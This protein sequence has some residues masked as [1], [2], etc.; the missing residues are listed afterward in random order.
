MTTTLAALLST[1]L[2]IASAATASD[3]EPPEQV[4]TAG[5]SFEKIIYPTPVLFDADGDEEREL[6]VGDLMGNVWV[7]EADGASAG[8]AWTEAENLKTGE[9]PL[10]LNNW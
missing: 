4:T 7:C 8:T 10:K 6:I 5:K 1:P 2:L 3:F 9:K